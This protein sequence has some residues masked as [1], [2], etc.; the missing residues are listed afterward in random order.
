MAGNLLQPLNF[1]SEP[2]EPQI[3]WKQWIS[4]FMIYL[5]AVGGDEF[6]AGRKRAILLH[7]LGVEGQ[8]VFVTIPDCDASPPSGQD[9]FTLA[10]SLLEN[11]FA[12]AINVVAERYKFKQRFQKEGESFSQFISALRELAKTCDYGDKHDEMLRDQI[13][14]KTNS[15]KV[16]DRLLMEKEL[17]LSKAITIARR[18]E[19][20]LSDSRTF[21]KASKIHGASS[22][23]QTVNK[24]RNHPQSKFKHHGDTI[25]KG[26]CYRCGSNEHWANSKECP[27]VGKNC[28]KCSKVGHYARMCNATT[29]SAGTRPGGVTRGRS[30]R[31]AGNRVQE[32]SSADVMDFPDDDSPPCV[33]FTAVS[34]SSELT[35]GESENIHNVTAQTATDTHVQ[36]QV[37]KSKQTVKPV[38]CTVEV[39]GVEISPL[40][41]TGSPVSLLTVKTFNKHFLSE[42]L[43]SPRKAPNLIS[44]TNHTIDVEGIFH[45]RIRYNNCTIISN[46]YVVRH[47]VDII[48]RDLI[49]SLKINIINVGESLKCNNVLGGSNVN[50]CSQSHNVTPKARLIR[51]TGNDSTKHG[52]A[53]PE[54]CNTKSNDVPRPRSANS[55]ECSVNVNNRHMQP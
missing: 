43:L 36:Q 22:S 2:G 11:Q 52:K 16:R 6:S 10:V 51:P 55:E 44:F 7:C 17:D 29:V 34:T 35:T 12:K 31:Q 38:Y 14:E 3:P 28:Q 26:V 53:R 32:V 4:G 24:I 50:D 9:V 49:Q 41:D 23:F 27:A 37:R 15:N 47:G 46:V 13:I 33:L 20:A 45:A 48:G 5:S 40:L 19:D 8:R 54:S 25:K 18:I 1:L 39:N 21:A 42:A 30:T